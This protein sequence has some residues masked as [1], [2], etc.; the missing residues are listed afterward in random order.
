VNIDRNY[1][2]NNAQVRAENIQQGLLFEKQ[3][4]ERHVEETADA[5]PVSRCCE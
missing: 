4:H 2:L 3:K 5:A 1:E